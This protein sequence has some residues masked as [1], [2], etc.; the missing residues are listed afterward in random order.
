MHASGSSQ[1]ETTSK[2]QEPKKA[3]VVYQLL[4]ST[5]D[6]TSSDDDGVFLSVKVGNLR[7]PTW[8]SISFTE[9]QINQL[10]IKWVFEYLSI[11][12]FFCTCWIA[13]G[14]YHTEGLCIFGKHG[15]HLYAISL[16][17]T[18]HQ[19]YG[20]VQRKCWKASLEA[21]RQLI[22]KL[23]IDSPLLRNSW[24]YIRVVRVLYK[25]LYL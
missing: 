21:V 4:N 14:R 6:N 23:E 8:F 24:N 9:F 19:T 7:P 15:I 11:L 2:S 16:V 3:T 5:V 22:A 1:L 17:R 25:L 20:S 18:S 12:R 10:L 13:Y